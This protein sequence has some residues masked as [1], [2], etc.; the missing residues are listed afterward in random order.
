MYQQ[1]SQNQPIG[2]YFQSYPFAD[3]EYRGIE[4]PFR[5]VDTLATFYH[6]GIIQTAFFLACG[7]GGVVKIRFKVRRV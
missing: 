1:F 3:S 7:N 6:P 2:L 5:V 4:M